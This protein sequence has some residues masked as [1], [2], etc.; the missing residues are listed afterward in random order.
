MPKDL[1]RE[2]ISTGKIIYEW[3]V[4][5]YEQ[6]DRNRRWYW[7]AS[8]VGAVLILFGLLTA[9][10]LFVLVLVLF[11]IVLFLHDL[12]PPLDVYFG[13]TE[14]GIILGK[15]FY[16]YTE[17]NNFW[18]IYNPPEVKNLYF[19]LDNIV[20]HRIQVPL[21]DYDP[22]PI[23]DYLLQFVEEDLNEEEEPFSDRLARILKI[24]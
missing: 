9:D 7:I 14:T 10:Y 21:L 11:G 23:R 1:T 8:I 15:K 20:K 4:K 6:Y 18:I 16:R 13:I 5:E 12:R 17:L 19:S 2:N 24:H 3:L 22:R